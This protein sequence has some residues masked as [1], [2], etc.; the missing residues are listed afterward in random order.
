MRLRRPGW[1]EKL[2]SEN[3]INI[4]TNTAQGAQSI[5]FVVSIPLYH[6]VS[7]CGPFDCFFFFFLFAMFFF[8]FDTESYCLDG[9]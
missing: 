7:D 5:I 4:Y 3:K 9:N 1:F 6:R 2:F 8:N